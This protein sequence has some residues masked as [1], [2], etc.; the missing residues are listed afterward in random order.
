MSPAAGRNRS[1]WYA[2]AWVLSLLAHGLA[3]SAAIVLV[4]DLTLAPQPEP[5]HWDV[6]MVEPAVEPVTESMPSSVAPAPAEPVKPK[7]VVRPAPQKPVERVFEQQIMEQPPPA[8]HPV[9]PVP[10]TDPLIE[11]VE[12]ERIAEPVPVEPT[13]SVETEPISPVAAAEP[14]PVQEDVVQ[15]PLETAP[16]QPI[17]PPVVA[18]APMPRPEVTE[19]P[20]QQSAISE[21]P[22]QE[23]VLSQP[24]PSQPTEV[25]SVRSPSAVTAPTRADYSWLA[26]KLWKRVAAL[27]RYPV[28]A[29]VNRQEGKVVLRAVIREDGHLQALRVHESSGH[30]VLDQD[31]MEV[32]RQAC[33]LHLDH[34][35]GRPEVVMMVPISYTLND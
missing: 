14:T 4:S 9:E 32:V 16:P 22:A 28:E 1:Q 35:L 7:P 3:I 13:P 27:K 33:P 11:R 12:P 2:G 10:T 8:S 23:P 18:A 25:A 26:Q 30:L 34:P 24:L 17:A 19:E 29:R 15:P 6:A 21:P 20:K 5:F 31:A